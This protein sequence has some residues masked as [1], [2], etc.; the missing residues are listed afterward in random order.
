M[1]SLYDIYI[2]IYILSSILIQNQYAYLTHIVE[3]DTTREIGFD[4]TFP[5]VDTHVG[6]KVGLE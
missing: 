5:K 6:V 2:Y 3:Q 4:D 1:V